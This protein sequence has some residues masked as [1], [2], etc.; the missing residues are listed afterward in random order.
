[1]TAIDLKFSLEK[2][3]GLMEYLLTQQFVFDCLTKVYNFY[4]SISLM[5][6]RNKVLQFALLWK[7]LILSDV[8]ANNEGGSSK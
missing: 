5:M 6:K 4:I 3:N 2:R 8:L 7:L 1:M